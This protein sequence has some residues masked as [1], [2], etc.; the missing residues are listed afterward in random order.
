M[1]L[2]SKKKNQVIS[3]AMHKFCKQRNKLLY[4]NQKED[5]HNKTKTTQIKKTHNKSK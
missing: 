4:N 5:L 1:L 2:G 3:Q